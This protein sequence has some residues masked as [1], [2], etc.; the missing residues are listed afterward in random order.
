MIIELEKQMK[1]AAQ[2]L[3]FE[4]AAV[5]RD[6]VMEMRRMLALKDAGADSDMPEWER[7]RALDEAGISYEIE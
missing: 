6:Q 1:E 5:L 4:K 2:A 3:E 7:M